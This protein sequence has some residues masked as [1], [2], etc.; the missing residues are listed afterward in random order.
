MYYIG[1]V[2][3]PSVNI[4]TQSGSIDFGQLPIVLN[5]T[6]VGTLHWYY[7]NLDTPLDEQ[8]VLLSDGTLR[9]NITTIPLDRPLSSYF[10]AANNSLGVA[11]SRSPNSV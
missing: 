2:L 10:C 6:G 7:G 1:E 8:T 11:R 5:C 4:T 3:L 9:L